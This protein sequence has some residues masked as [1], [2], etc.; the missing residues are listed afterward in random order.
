MAGV[1]EV[2]GNVVSNSTVDFSSGAWTLGNVYADGTDTIYKPPV[3]GKHATYAGNDCGGA[4]TA[5]C[6][7]S[8]HSPQAK[9]VYS[10]QGS[11]TNSNA[12]ILGTANASTAWPSCPVPAGSG[13]TCNASSFSL[14]PAQTFPSVYAS[15]SWSGSTVSWDD[16]TWNYIDDSADACTSGYAPGLAS[17]SVY[18][19]IASATSPT[20]VVTP[21]VFGLNYFSGVPKPFTINTDI[22]V[23]ASAGFN[24]G[25]WSSVALNG[26][27]SNDFFAIVPCDAT[28]ASGHFPQSHRAQSEGSTCNPG[29]GSPT[30]GDIWLQ[31]KLT[32]VKTFLYTPD[33]ICTGSTP[34]M[35]GQVYAGGYIDMNGGFAMT[36]DTSISDK[37]S[38]SMNWS[39]SVVSLQ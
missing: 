38:G 39:A 10:A 14:P 21:C 4:S 12:P 23:F 6:L 16:K 1:C 7:D 2:D 33:N 18:N 25:N 17:V 26:T 37:V 32:N 15:S 27:G 29:S 13:L 8:G 20:L 24:F 9:S 19:D 31:S 28:C 5:V 22:A 36:A 34:A 11:V 35:T 30:Y 3:P